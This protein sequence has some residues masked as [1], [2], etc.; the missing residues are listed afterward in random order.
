MGYRVALTKQAMEQIRQVVHY[1]AYNLKESET[2]KKWSADLRKEIAGL[3]FM[4]MRF[5]LTEEEPWHT[6]GIRKMIVK[7]L[8]VYYLVDEEKKQV[9]IIAVILARR[10]QL[11][12]LTELTF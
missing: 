8:L 10:D 2:A 6:M 1:I 7:S 11:A 12:A 5:P 3:D 4:P 9:S